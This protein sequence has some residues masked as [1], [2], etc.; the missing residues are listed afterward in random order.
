GGPANV[1]WPHSPVVAVGG[2]RTRSPLSGI[3]FGATLKDLA[4][5]FTLKRTTPGVFAERSW[6]TTFA[7][8]FRAATSVVPA[9]VIV[10]AQFTVAP[11]SPVVRRTTPTAATIRIGRMFM[12]V[13]LHGRQ[14][15][16]GQKTGI[17][18]SSDDEAPV[19]ESRQFVDTSDAGPLGVRRRGTTG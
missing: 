10:G 18:P 13:P 17:R 4:L 12:S 14:S 3:W 7:M 5:P 9:S 2:S 6:I 11:A 16:R 8:S 1:A 19:P 15:S